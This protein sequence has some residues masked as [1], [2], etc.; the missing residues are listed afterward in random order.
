MVHAC[1]PS[2]WEFEAS[3]GYIA[4]LCLKIKI[5]GVRRGGLEM[6]LT[7][8]CTCLECGKVLVSKTSKQKMGF[9][10]NSLIRD[11]INSQRLKQDILQ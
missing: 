3:L 6:W 4:R 10:E 2:T 9:S 7:F 5:N 11:K 1:N 8:L